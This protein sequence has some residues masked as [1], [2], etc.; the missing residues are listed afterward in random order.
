[1]RHA[2]RSRRNANHRRRVV[3]AMQQGQ[4]PS[5]KLMDGLLVRHHYFRFWDAL[6][7]GHGLASRMRAFDA[8]K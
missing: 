2:T 4:G 7:T 8:R 3:A 1:M 5:K 6:E